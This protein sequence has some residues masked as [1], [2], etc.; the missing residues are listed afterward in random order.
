M[1][2]MVAARKQRE[3][4]YG[5]SDKETDTQKTAE[6]TGGQEAD[7]PEADSLQTD[8]ANSMGA[9]PIEQDQCVIAFPGK[10]FS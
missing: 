2:G 10:E 5:V 8:G 4:Y 3:T 9:D 6:H 7:G 1:F